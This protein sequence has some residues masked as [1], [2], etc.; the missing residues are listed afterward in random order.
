LWNC[1]NNSPK[2][3]LRKK[4]G[5][6]RNKAK[7]YWKA[8]STGFKQLK[9]TKG[10]WRN[11]LANLKRK[12]RDLGQDPTI[13]PWGYIFFIIIFFFVTVLLQGGLTLEIWVTSSDQEILQS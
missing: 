9:Q 2:V 12:G 10:E 1:S 6:S 3:R 11:C 13:S 4:G 8:Q 5:G 7:K